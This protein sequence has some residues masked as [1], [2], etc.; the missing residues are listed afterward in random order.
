M[1]RDRWLS[2]EKLFALT[3]SCAARP[4][5]A[6]VE[7]AFPECDCSPAPSI[8]KSKISC[9]LISFVYFCPTIALPILLPRNDKLRSFKTWQLK[10][11]LAIRAERASIPQE[12]RDSPSPHLRPLVSG[13]HVWSSTCD[14]LRNQEK[15][16]CPKIQEG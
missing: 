16:S 15:H 11:T 7:A 3:A 14:S 13:V 4:H 5:P 6:P 10:V 2:D 12:H 9:H 1:L 8:L